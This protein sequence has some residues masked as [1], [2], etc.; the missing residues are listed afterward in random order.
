MNENLHLGMHPDADELSTFVEGA[1]NARERQQ[2]L[3]HLA[4]CAKCRSIVFLLQ[5]AAEPEPAVSGSRWEWPWR[6]WLTPAGLAAA[7]LACGL[8]TVVYLRAHRETP[9]AAG[10]NA[11]LQRP[12]PPQRVAP[13]SPRNDRPTATTEKLGNESALRTP[14]LNA[15]KRTQG[16]AERPGANEQ[17]SVVHE[18]SRTDSKEKEIAPQGENFSLPGSAA[19]AGASASSTSQLAPAAQP[20]PAPAPA[21]GHEPIDLRNRNFAALSSAPLL[22]IEHDSGPDDG[23]SEVSGRVTDQTGAMIS[24][25]TVTL[26]NGAG[27]MRQTTSNPDG[28]FDLT[29]VLP[30]QYELGVTAR[31]FESYRQTVDLKPRDMAMLDAPLT[32]GA[33]SQTVTVQAEAPLLETS[34][35]SVSEVQVAELPSRMPAQMSVTLGKRILS[36]DGEGALFV[37]RNRG[38]SWKRVKPQWAGKVAQIQTADSRA[39]QD[40]RRNSAG[41]KAPAAFQLTTDSGA[42][43]VSED[44]TRWRER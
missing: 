19:S 33:A 6:R 25:A 32:V 24:G 31:G 26:R 38:K 44:G 43:W 2:M 17:P 8:A 4:E 10:Q 36:L 35:A 40:K 41:E 42:V 13:E 5:G 18:S 27:K 37:S 28:S 21:E 12:Q 22:K 1:A 29:E 20:K 14:G 3:A 34:S 39:V 15:G 23:T 16:S 30:G 11:Q 9:P 7:A